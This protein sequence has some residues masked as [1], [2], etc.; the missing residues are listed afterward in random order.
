MRSS[1]IAASILVSL[2]AVGCGKEAPKKEAPTPV[3]SAAPSA[4]KQPP[5]AEAPTPSSAPTSDTAPKQSHHARTITVAFGQH[6][7]KPEKEAAPKI[8][9][10]PELGK[11]EKSTPPAK[12]P[13]GEYACGASHSG[14]H[15]VPLMCLEDKNHEKDEKAARPLVSFA[16]L[17]GKLRPLPK[18]VDHREEQT[19]AE[20]RD[21]G[22]AGTCTTFSTSAA[23]D[24]A[25]TL[26]SGSPS[27]ISTM[28]LWGRY[29]QPDLGDALIASIGQTFAAEEAW[30]YDAKT[31]WPWRSCPS[32]SAKGEKM[33]GPCGKAVDK[34]KLGELE[35]KHEVV[36]EQVEWLPKD[37][38]ILRRKIAAGD[39]PVFAIKLPRHFSPVGKVGSR[40]IPD[41]KEETGGHALALAGYAVGEKGD[42]YYLIHNSWGTK[43][44]DGG[45]A[46]IHEATLSKH[47]FGGFGIIDARPMKGQKAHR[48]GKVCPAG[49]APDSLTGACAAECKEGGPMHNGV[50]PE[51]SDCAAGLVNL[52]GECVGAAPTDTGKDEKS[53]ISWKCG[54]G[55]CAYTLPKALGKCSGE[56]CLLSCPAPMFHAAKDDRGLTCV[57]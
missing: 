47:M 12:L 30:P 28:E 2:A 52:W 4:P 3:A 44:G 16:H 49:H 55:G 13:T 23:I 41:Y 10:L 40:Y 48:E 27:H 42:N 25:V 26:W 18:V 5:V 46:W 31:A 20:I 15:D 39:D 1:F 24:H 29:H 32:G 43:W 11:Q 34:A 19:E 51:L 22:T 35:K 57:Q 45:Y 17:K 36:V 9:E 56:P 14:E 37:F 53:G 38:E 8:P 50:C 33:D 54:P 6:P 21:Q 7:P